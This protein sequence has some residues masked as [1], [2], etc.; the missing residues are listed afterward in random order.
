MDKL[1]KDELFKIAIMLEL[2]ELI[3]FCKTSHRINN[4]ICEKDDIW[5]YRIK[6]DFPNYVILKNKNYK[7]LYKDILKNSLPFKFDKNKTYYI[8]DLYKAVE[9]GYNT[10]E[11]FEKFVR[12]LDIT[13]LIVGKGEYNDGNYVERYDIS[14]YDY[15]WFVEDEIGSYEP[16][17]SG[18]VVIYFSYPDKKVKYGSPFQSRQP[19]NFLLWSK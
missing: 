15:V 8:L 11:E 10:R 9:K 5:L 16:L 2:P 18:Q 17:N 4:L 3:A 13:N 19:Q 14:L 6:T 7:E 1:N 12:K